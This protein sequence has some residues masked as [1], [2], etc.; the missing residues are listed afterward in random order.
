MQDK[1][2]AQRLHADGEY[3][4]FFEVYSVLKAGTFLHA[5]DYLPALEKMV[6]ALESPPAVSSP[7]HAGTI[8]VIVTGLAC[9]LPHLQVFDFFEEAE[10]CSFL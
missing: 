2:Y 3:L 9:Q 6:A 10:F 4:S 7:Q 5:D 1:L 8:P